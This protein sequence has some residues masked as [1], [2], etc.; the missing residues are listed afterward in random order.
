MRLKYGRAMVDF[1]PPAHIQWQILQKD[2]PFSPLPEMQIIEQAV[3]DLIQRLEEA[4]VGNHAKLL[5]VVPDHTRRCR[6]GVLLPL[7]TTSLEER[8]GASLHILIANGSHVLQ[9]EETIRSLVGDGIY[10][11]YPVIQ[12]DALD[13]ASLVYL[14]DSSNG[15]AFFLNRKIKEVDF[16]I[17]IGG[18]LYHYFAGFGGG[19]KMLFPGI[20]GYESIRANH[21]RTVDAASGRFHPFCHEGN[22]TTNPVYLDLVEVM[23]F[24]PNVLSLQLAL[25]PQGKVVF[26]AAGKVLP[27]HKQV[28]KKVEEIYSIPLAEKAD[29]VVA[30]A[31]GFPADVNLIQ[32][33]KS[34]HHA[35]QAMKENGWL[36][37]LAECIEGI[38]SQTFLPYFDYGS[39]RNIGQRLLEDYQINGHTALALKAK[40]EKANIVF[41]SNLDPQMVEKIGMIPARNLAQAWELTKRHL[42]PGALGH[43]LPTASVHVPVVNHSS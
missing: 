18:I 20:A 10:K 23:R 9:P 24:V 25:S 22:I 32:S 7:L 39:S 33:H 43:I 40:A 28:C 41:V 21:R 16:I 6:L 3:L 15:T 31:G 8:F 34:I 36:I 17:T 13:R 1:E 2:L 38:G 19:A 42:N 37:I 29:V 12:H 35:F 11:K 30:S 14:G 27:T 4:G 5:L 26:A